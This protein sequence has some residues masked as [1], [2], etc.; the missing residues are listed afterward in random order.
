MG[1]FGQVPVELKGPGEQAAE[2][3]ND[4]LK[5]LLQ[6]VLPE[7]AASETLAPAPT[8]STGLGVLPGLGVGGE[9][10]EGG[11]SSGGRGPGL[12]AGTEFFGVQDRARSFAYVIDTSGSMARNQ[13]LSV[14]KAELLASL[15][16]LNE[17][18]SFG[19]VLYNL[20]ATFFS[21]LLQPATAARKEQVVRHLREVQP[22]GGTDHIAALKAG[23]TL[24]PEVIFFLTD[25]DLMTES[26]V[27]EILREVGS[28]RIQAIELGVGPDL[29]RSNPLKTLAASTGGSYRYLDTNQFAQGRGSPLIRPP[30]RRRS[31]RFDNGGL[32]GRATTMPV[33][34]R[35][36]SQRGQR[37]EGDGGG[38]RHGR[39]GDVLQDERSGSGAGR[40]TDQPDQGRGTRAEIDRIEA[41]LIAGGARQ[42]REREVRA[43]AA[44]GGHDVEPDIVIGVEP[45]SADQDCIP[46]RGR[47]LDV[48]RVGR[49]RDVK[50]GGRTGPVEVVGVRRAGHTGGRAVQRGLNGR[51]R[52]RDIHR[53]VLSGGADDP[54]E[55]IGGIEVHTERDPRQA[56]PKLP[57]NVAAAVAVSMVYR[58]LPLPTPYRNPSWGRKSIPTTVSP[59]TSPEIDPIRVVAPGVVASKVTRLSPVVRPKAVIWA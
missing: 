56:V 34:H 11:G 46:A 25:A 38:F 51:N 3:A 45:E 22:F 31:G 9:S 49:G 57:M 24:K 14:A 30:V 20:R 36:E 53:Q 1:G 19:L 37:R 10:G 15:N 26:E 27:Q 55:T 4:A 42:R 58:L 17:Q 7:A 6:D 52:G 50:Q 47:R 43:A 33:E 48:Q 12:G 59:P 16:K 13:A 2:A 21:S 54:Q 18:T 29:R 39:Q 35:A 44:A 41:G 5:T 40:G 28:T 8:S 23:L 32:G